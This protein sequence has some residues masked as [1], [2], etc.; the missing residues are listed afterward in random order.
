MMRRILQSFMVILILSTTPAL[1]IV[2]KETTESKV[3]SITLFAHSIPGSLGFDQPA[4][5]SVVLGDV[6]QFNA[7]NVTD[8][9]RLQWASDNPAIVSV[10]DNGEVTAKALGTTVIRVV[11]AGMAAECKV[12]VKL[13]PLIINA[14]NRMSSTSLRVRWNKVASASGYV[15]YRSTKEASGYKAIKTITKGS[16]LTYTNKKLKS[17]TKYYYKVRAYKTVSGKKVYGD[18]CSVVAG[19]PLSTPSVKTKSGSFDTITI[20]WKKVKGATGYYIE[21]SETKSGTY[22]VIKNISNDY[23]LQATDDAIDPFKTYYYKVTAYADAA[24]WRT[25]ATSSIKSC[26]GVLGTPVV[27][28]MPSETG[29]RLE[30]Y[31]GVAGADYY[32]VYRATSKNGKYT[33]LSMTNID[34][35]YVDTTAVS[36]KTYYYKVRLKNTY[37][38][39]VRYS[40]YS[41]VKS[42]VYV[43]RTTGLTGTTQTGAINLSW[44][45]T[46]GASGYVI[47]RSTDGG[48]SFKALKTITSVKTLKYKD[49]SVSTGI[50]YTY[51]IRAYKK[52]GSSKKYGAYSTVYTV[53]Y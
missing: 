26:K 10:D 17:G 3:G 30:W 32:E 19:V 22:V 52:V 41:K 46:S 14:V 23:V 1:E 53:T 15:V 13:E 47:E 51:R 2:A 31:P 34:A 27:T 24:I 42:I 21:R 9:K 8:K 18:Y 35:H 36:G 43:A 4:E 38:G 16:T 48:A 5:L 11:Y 29:V 49:S 25:F 6:M 28:V 44:D 12:T 39:V 45:K 50:T 7:T 20:S 37:N 40:S 33:A